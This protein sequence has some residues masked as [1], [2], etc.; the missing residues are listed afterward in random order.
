[1]ERAERVSPVRDLPSVSV[2]VAFHRPSLAL[3]RRQIESLL[4]Q[5]DVKLTI[6]AV[7]DGAETAADAALMVLLKTAGLKTAGL[8]TAGASIIIHDKAVGARRAFTE[9]LRHVVA[10]CGEN[11]FFAFC[12]QD[13]VWQ[14]E[15]LSRSIAV[16][17]ERAATLVHCDARVLDAEGRVIA[18]SL[19]R[20]E[21]RKEAED[22]FGMLLLNTVTGMTAVFSA[23]T[24]RAAVAVL[25]RYQGSLLH[26]HVT[27]AVA[28][29]LGRVAL[30][31]EAL[32]DYVQ[33]G[34]NQIGAKPPRS[35]LRFRAVGLPHL[36][37]YR[38][39]SREIFED[40]RALA[41]ALAQEGLLPEDLDVMFLTGKR[42]AETTFLSNYLLRIAGLV[43]AR[44]FRRAGLAARML[45]VGRRAL[46]RR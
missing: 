20:F 11:E 12:D 40:R 44:Q 19:H 1:M 16:L 4:A 31:D 45:D 33:H 5:R 9:G 43:R 36:S 2:V 10:R 13:D 39:T 41:Y 28:A 24:A 30:L 42:P 32:V 15:K 37:A 26:D 35:V 18:P 29:S 22:L 7:V 17:R 38:D 8:K 23:Q 46:P 21:A 14:P 3:A 27:A 25:D 34:E 6:A